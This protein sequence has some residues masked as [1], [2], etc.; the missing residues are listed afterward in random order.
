[1]EPRPPSA[2]PV[3]FAPLEASRHGHL[4]PDARTLEARTAEVRASRAAAHGSAWRAFVSG[5]QGVRVSTRRART[6]MCG[7]ACRARGACR[8]R[9]RRSRSGTTSASAATP[10]GC[11][12]STRS[13]SSPSAT[14]SSSL[15]STVMISC[16]LK[17]SSSCARAS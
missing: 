10:A 15:P 7:A 9:W 8:R 5:Q 12:R 3:V 2:F 14:S 4:T 11:G 6:L 13:A 17:E 1:M 16:R